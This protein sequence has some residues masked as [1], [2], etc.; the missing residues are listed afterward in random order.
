MEQVL[1]KEL[2][3]RIVNSLA[4]DGA[5]KPMPIPKSNM[6]ILDENGVKHKIVL[7]REDKLIAFTESDVAT[8]I[9]AFV[10]VLARYLADGKAVRVLNFGMFRI[11]RHRGHTVRDLETKELVRLDPTYKVKFTPGSKIKT[12]ERLVALT[13]KENGTLYDGFDDEIDDDEADDG[14]DMEEESYE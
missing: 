14:V 12:A 9:D 10:D 1:R 6:Y 13:A 5:G 4:D 11:K 7:K 8:V 3:K 2:L